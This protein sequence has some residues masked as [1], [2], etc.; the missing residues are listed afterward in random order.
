LRQFQQHYVGGS[1]VSTVERANRFR[2]TV[3]ITLTG[4]TGNAPAGIAR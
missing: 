1:Y 4:A 2:K 3:C